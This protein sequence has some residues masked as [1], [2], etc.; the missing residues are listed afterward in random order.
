MMTVDQRKS[1]TKKALGHHRMVGG[2][3]PLSCD[4]GGEAGLL[5]RG[6]VSDDGDRWRWP[7]V[8]NRPTS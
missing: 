1:M 3:R 2:M 6:R 4:S 7:G 8:V 5:P